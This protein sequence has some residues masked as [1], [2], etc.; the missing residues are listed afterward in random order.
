MP[1]IFSSFSNTF[2]S[3]LQSTGVRSL[4]FSKLISS[5][6]II[7]IPMLN[8]H[9]PGF[10]IMRSPPSPSPI[11]PLCRPILW[12]PPMYCAAPTWAAM[13]Y[14]SII[15]TTL[16]WAPPHQWVVLSCAIV[17]R[18]V[19]T[20]NS[21]YRVLSIILSFSF[22]NHIKGITFSHDRRKFRIELLSH[23]CIV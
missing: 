20:S 18:E 8:I 23:H 1:F 19:S 16:V 7:W 11:P 13:T 22:K 5:F 2:I 6:K 12:I 4:L 15:P 9:L 3:F 14:Q 21:N 10:P 17:C